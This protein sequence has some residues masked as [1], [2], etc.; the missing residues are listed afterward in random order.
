MV[1]INVG[2]YSFPYS[3]I[4]LRTDRL[5]AILGMDWL[6]RYQ[7]KLDCGAKTVMLTQ[8]NGDTVHYFTLGSVLPSGVNSHSPEISLCFMEGM[9]DLPPPELLEVDVVCEFPDVFPEELPGLPPDRSVEF[10]IE[11][12]PGTAPVSK[13]GRAHV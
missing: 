12:P 4:S 11:L 13:I 6:A 3:L 2:S 5:D 7:A 9:E 8:D 1:S 10:V